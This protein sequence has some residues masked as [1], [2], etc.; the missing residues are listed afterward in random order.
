MSR[1]PVGLQN[2]EIVAMDSFL[3]IGATQGSGDFG[4]MQPG[5]FAQLRR[6][7]IGEAASIFSTAIAER[8]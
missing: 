4:R 7:V 1:R 8:H 3:E 2:R 5:D 6:G